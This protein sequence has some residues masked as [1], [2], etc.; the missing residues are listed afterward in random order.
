MLTQI[1]EKP[2]SQLIVELQQKYQEENDQSNIFQ[3]LYQQQVDLES[4]TES[5]NI[6]PALFSGSTGSQS[7]HSQEGVEKKIKKAR[8]GQIP[9]KTNQDDKKLSNE[10]TDKKTLQMIRNRI[11][12]QNSRDRKKAYLQKL[13]EDFNKQSN[14]LQELTEQVSYLQQQ[15]EEVQKLNSHLQSQQSSLICINCGCKQFV[16]EEEA[17]ISIS[18]NRGLGKLGFSFVVIL[19]IFACFTINFDTSAQNLQS[20]PQMSN[21]KPLIRHLNNTD[22]Q[23]GILEQVQNGRIK[24]ITDLMEYII[25]IQLQIL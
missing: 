9:N 2:L 3:K 20:I 18:K 11:S 13:E 8:K 24:G 15:L 25:R 16:L 22:Q 6:V 17:P 23:Y 14:C 4:S 5:S 10:T 1:K 19:T 12:A 21:E 7:S